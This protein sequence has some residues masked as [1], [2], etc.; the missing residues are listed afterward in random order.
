MIR[1][2]TCTCS[3]PLRTVF[4]GVLAGAAGTAAMDLLQYT[5]FLHD[6]GTDNFWQ[7]ETAAGLKGWDEAPAPAQAGKRIAEGLLQ[8]SLDPGKARLMTNL[9]HWAYGSCWGAAYAILAGSGTK[10]RVSYGFPFGLFV[11]STG[12]ALLPSTGIY[13]N[14][15]EYEP[16]VLWKDA[17]AHFTYGLTAAAIFKLVGRRRG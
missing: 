12:Y 6:G 7:W 2:K 15:W 9:V 3:T 14:I 8:R 13:K 1:I 10:R 5:R 4:E 16:K 11:W 17:G